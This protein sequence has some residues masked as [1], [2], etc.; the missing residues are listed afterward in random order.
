MSLILEESVLL[1][2]VSPGAGG[3]GVLIRDGQGR[4][5]VRG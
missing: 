1:A 5:F 2:P 3:T 4:A